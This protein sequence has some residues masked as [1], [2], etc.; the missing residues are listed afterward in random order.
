[1]NMKTISDKIKPVAVQAAYEGGR[2]TLGYFQ[3]GRYRIENK[4]DDSPVTEADQNAEKIIVGYIQKFFPKH[5]ILGEEFGEI[6]GDEP[7]RWI[8]DPIDGTK[9]FIHH[10]PLYGTTI[11]VQ[12]MET[13]EVE[14]GVCYY[15]ALDEMV[16]AQKGEGT[17]CNGRR[18]FVSDVKEFGQSVLT[19]TDLLDLSK[20]SLIHL[21]DEL[22]SRVKFVR[23][24][25]DCF[26][27]KLIACGQAEIMIDPWMKIWDIAP[28]IPVITEAGGKIFSVD[29]KP[30][31][32]SNAI[33]SCNA[34]LC[35]PVRKMMDSVK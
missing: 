17:Y 20:T 7:F 26:G 29:G 30:V 4:P 10:I 33:I 15:P 23:T 3:T 34:A 6:K 18:V 9:S 28:L 5:S 21:F 16:C 12:N 8:I 19:L 31:L 32:E 27:H 22:K 13:G 24:W 25:G 1:M 2:S 35:E 11:G 14:T